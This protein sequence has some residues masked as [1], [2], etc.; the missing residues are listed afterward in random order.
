MVKQCHRIL[1][2]VSDEAVELA[3]AVAK[4]GKACVFVPYSIQVDHSLPLK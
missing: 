3:S 4:N 1:V 2:S